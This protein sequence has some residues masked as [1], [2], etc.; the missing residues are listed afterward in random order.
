VNFFIDSFFTNIFSWLAQEMRGS[1]GAIRKI[2]SITSGMRD[3][4][5]HIV[6]RGESMNFRV[7]SNFSNIFSWF[8]IEAW[9]FIKNAIRVI[10][11]LTSSPW[12]G[13]D[14]INTRNESM[15]FF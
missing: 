9:I 7:N 10:R 3:W 11:G 15:Y 4:Q 2:R 13:E 14:Y 8:V 12:L 1:I 5:N 6:A